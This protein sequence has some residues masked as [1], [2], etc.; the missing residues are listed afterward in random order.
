MITKKEIGTIFMHAREF[1]DL[2]IIVGLL[3]L[4]Y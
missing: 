2:W 3:M 1:V 4:E